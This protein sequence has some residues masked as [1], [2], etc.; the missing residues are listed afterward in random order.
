MFCEGFC[1]PWSDF[2]PDV[3]HI[4]EPVARRSSC[5]GNQG[6]ALN[7]FVTSCNGLPLLGTSLSLWHSRSFFG[8][9]N[10][11]TGSMREIFPRGHE[12][13]VDGQRRRQI[14]SEITTR[15]STI[16]HLVCV[17]IMNTIYEVYKDA[18]SSHSLS[19][20]FLEG[21]GSWWRREVSRRCFWYH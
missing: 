20:I 19:A 10:H 3:V 2:D 15:K 1:F 17:I 11:C 7:F 8:R 4:P 5:E 18:A 16:V 13:E 6:F 12:P 9:N 21:R 14:S